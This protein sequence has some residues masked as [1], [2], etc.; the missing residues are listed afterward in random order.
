M[1]Q[2]PSDTDLR[3]ILTTTQVI[4]MVG[5]SLNPARPSYGVAGYL[6]GQGYRVIGVNPGLAGQ[7]LFG[8]PIVASIADLPAEVDML[9][10]FRRSE[11]VP[12][13]VEEAIKALPNLRT[14]WLQLGVISDAAEQ[15]AARAG[16]I[17][18]QDRCPKIDHARLIR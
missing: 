13:A 9:D 5:A 15:M 18:V 1:T 17:F 8:T 14:I 12:E 4:G 11:A 7:M 3:D 6:A 2:A 10:V 16:I